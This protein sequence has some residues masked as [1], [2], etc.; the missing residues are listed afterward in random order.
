MDL[1]QHMLLTG[2]TSAL[3]GLSTRLASEIN[4]MLSKP[5]YQS[6]KRLCSKMRFVNTPFPSNQLSWVGGSLFAHAKIPHGFTLDLA[7]FEAL[8]SVP[9]WISREP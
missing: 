2:G 9:D 5:S 8:D 3:P 1:V 4:S 6:M 7:T